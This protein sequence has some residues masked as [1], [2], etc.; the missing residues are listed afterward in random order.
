MKGG[1][2]FRGWK[3]LTSRGFFSLNDKSL[4]VCVIGSGPAGF[5]TAE[6]MLKAHERAEVDILDRLPTPFGLV[7]SGVAPDHPETKIV[8][9]QFSRVASNERCS[10]FGNV[11]L[12]SDVSLSELRD[13]YDVVVVAYGAESDRSLGVPGENLK[14]IYSAREFVWWYNGHPD[15][16]YM[17][18]DL[19]CTDTAV[20]LGQGNVALDVARILLRPMSELQT[21]DIAEHALVSLQEST[22]RFT[23]LEDEA[24]HRQLA[25]QRNCVKFLEE[26]KASRIQRRVYDLLCKSATSHQ[27]HDFAGQRELHFIFFRKPDKFLPSED[28]SRV[29]GVRLEKTCLKANGLSG[30]Q[31]AIGT[32]Q[33]EDLNCGLVL[34]SIGYKSVPVDGLPF[35]KYR[36]GVVPNVRGRVLSSDQPE[37]VNIEQ[38]LYVVGWL[39]RGPT[40]IVATNLYC[41]EETVASILEDID[42]GLIAS[43]SGSPKPG[44]Q[45]LLQALEDKNVRF[46]PFGGWEKIDSKEKLEGQLRNK[47][48]E[49]LTTWD[50]LLKAALG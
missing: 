9:N 22:I 15:C 12:G 1:L 33:F 14:E 40:G 28:Q 31:V 3:T 46:V 4:R 34:K 26:L 11:S 17:A 16:R 47:P 25:Q 36:A 30:K 29:G 50:E 49:K 19:K 39:K 13:M 43:P 24:Q 41:A 10:F 5:Y 45:G 21:T 35:D 37:N 6:K 23:W 7:R 2:L 8:V 27:G 18:P 48:R 44:R 42:N 38:G 20:V 32:G